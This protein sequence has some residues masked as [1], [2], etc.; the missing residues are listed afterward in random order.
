MDGILNVNKSLGITS[1]Q[2][3]A[4]IKRLSGMRKLGHAGTLD[5]AASGVLPVCLGRATRAIEY[6]LDLHKTYLA[7]IELGIA[8]DSYDSDGQIIGQ[9]D[10]S[11]I[12]SEGI[13]QALGAFSGTIMQT[14]PMFSALKH[15]GTPLYRLARAGITVD[16]PSRPAQIYRIELKGYE[17]PTLTLEVECGRGTY[18]RAIAHD[19]GEMLGCG[20]TLKNLTRL[21]YGPFGIKEAVT[22]PTLEDAFRKATIDKYLNTVDFAMAHIPRV[23]VNEEIASRLRYGEPL[24]VRV[25]AG[26][27]AGTTRLRVY[28]PDGQFLGIWELDP[29][30]NG[31]RAKKVFSTR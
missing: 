6:F 18:I 11:A 8:T 2:V 23:T 12:T 7:E 16:R 9:N 30:T 1:Y 22:L 14:P 20:G 26:A 24:D 31:Y 29:E 5:P 25:V 13:T 28:S 3:V 10:I 17:P 27:P 15:R 21:Q 4:T 19:L